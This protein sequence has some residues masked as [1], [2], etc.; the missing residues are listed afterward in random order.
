MTDG[1]DAAV[2]QYRDAARRHRRKALEHKEAG[3]PLNAAVERATAAR[4]S[5]AV[6][7]ELNDARSRI[8]ES[9]G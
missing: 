3:R 2:A 6:L 1:T 7:A 9:A 5:R 8:N 4:I